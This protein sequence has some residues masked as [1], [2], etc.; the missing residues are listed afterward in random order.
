MPC[1]SNLPG[2]EQVSSSP[3]DNMNLHPRCTSTTCRF[4]V[5]PAA[6]SWQS[7]HCKQKSAAKELLLKALT[8]LHIPCTLSV[9]RL[10]PSSLQQAGRWSSRCMAFPLVLRQTCSSSQPRKAGASD[11]WPSSKLPLTACRH[12][13]TF[14]VHLCRFCVL[15]LAASRQGRQARA[16]LCLHL[17]CL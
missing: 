2:A 7:R 12:A 15:P 5:L 11:P 10:A 9:C 1:G 4:F 8:A 16:V 14:P 17:H 6:S 3:L 13:L